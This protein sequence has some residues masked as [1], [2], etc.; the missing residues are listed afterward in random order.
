MDSTRK[1]LVLICLALSAISLLPAC[2]AYEGSIAVFGTKNIS[3]ELI[4]E[5]D[6]DISNNVSMAMA[7]QAISIN[8]TKMEG[9]NASIMIMSM[10]IGAENQ[11]LNQSEF[12][13][14]MENM[15]IGAIKLANG[16]ELGS[17]VVATPIGGNVTLHKIIMQSAVNRP[18]TES[19]MAFWDLDDFN[20]V[21][22]TSEM[23]L[24]ATTKI[25]ETLKIVP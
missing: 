20:H 3:F 24:N 22:L 5:P 18:A 2:S 17:I 11:T 7:V 19:I 25:V 15:F 6:Y 9:K 12:S 10:N 21:I 23:D 8:S 14:F 4:S 16:K 1:F 13:S